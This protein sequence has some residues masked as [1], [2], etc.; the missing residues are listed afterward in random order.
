MKIVSFDGGGYLGLASACF[1]EEIERYFKK[2]FHANFDLFCGTSTGAIIALGLASGMSGSEVRRL[3]EDLGPRIFWNKPAF[4]RH[5]RFVRGLLVSRYDD[6]PLRAALDKAFGQTRV[7]DI[8]RKGKFV[9]ITAFSVSSGKPRIFKTDHA[10][11]LN[12]DDGYL[13]RDVALASSAA[14]TFLPL[15]KLKS[16]TSSVEER[17]CDGGVFANHPA[18]LGYAEARFHLKVSAKDIQVLSVST[19][20]AD[21]A[22]RASTRNALQQFLLNRGVLL[23]GGR[24]FNIFVDATSDISHE[25][26]RRI[27]ACDIGPATLYERLEVQRPHGIDIDVTTKKATETLCQIGSELAVDGGVRK[28]LEPFFN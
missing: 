24:L 5:L 15:V 18:L 17:Y 21:L 16:P 12:R 9:L 14:P 13:V 6:R 19:P 27:A 4:M 22:E 11:E 2:T 20:R 1:V 26:L 10:P 3:Y 25:T 28:R 8:K 23:W 7:G